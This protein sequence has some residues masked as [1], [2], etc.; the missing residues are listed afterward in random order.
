MSSV[1][2]TVEEYNN[3]SARMC[4]MAENKGGTK[5]LADRSIEILADVKKSLVKDSSRELAIRYR[6][7]ELERHI[8]KIQNLNK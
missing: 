2:L 7:E 6:L 3:I 5:W 8:G 1:S 4:A